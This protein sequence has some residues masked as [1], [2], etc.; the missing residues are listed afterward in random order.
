MI[1]SSP[2]TPTDPSPED[3]P[4]LTCRIGD[5]VA[6]AAEL[7]QGQQRKGSAVPYLAHLLAVAALVLEAGGDED[8]AVAAL[9]H[10]ALEDTEAN[11]EEIESRFGSRVARVVAACTDTQEHPKPP[12]RQRKAR[13]LDGL[14]D[15]DSDEHVLLVVASDKIHNLGSILADHRRLGEGLWVRFRAGPQEQYWYYSEVARR[16]R[17]GLGGPLADTLDDLVSQFG[18]V[19][20]TGSATGPDR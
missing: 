12:W 9:L 1:W 2:V 18:L 8:D 20:G 19:V 17:A 10:D 5:A 13:F 6:W 7:H 4:V 3:F 15:P 14:D 16:V 11:G